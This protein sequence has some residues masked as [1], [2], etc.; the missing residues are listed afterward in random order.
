[1]GKSVCRER[2]RKTVCPAFKS[3]LVRSH[4][5]LKW[6]HHMQVM[7]LTHV[8]K[9]L[10]ESYVDDVTTHVYKSLVES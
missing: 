8:R 3:F 5:G 6:L 4:R 7:G 2:E 10:P 9:G 1:M